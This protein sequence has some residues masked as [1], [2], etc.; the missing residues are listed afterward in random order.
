MGM[1]PNAGTRCHF[2]MAVSGWTLGS[3]RSFIVGILSLLLIETL[4]L[5]LNNEH[6]NKVLAQI[7]AYFD[8]ITKN[9]AFAELRLLYGLKSTSLL[10]HQV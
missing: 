6:V 2:K 3:E 7:Q 10:G 8:G 9:D 1:W 5:R 4:K